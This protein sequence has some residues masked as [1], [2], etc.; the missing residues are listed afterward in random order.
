MLFYTIVPFPR[1]MT[2]VLLLFALHVRGQSTDKNYV[3]SRIYKIATTTASGNIK[4]AGQ[5]ISYID[6]LGREI[7]K[8]D[9][10][11]SPTL[12]GSTPAD[13]VSHF[14]YDSYGRPVRNYA[15]YPAQGNGA[16][17][18]TANLE[19]M[20]Y[21][22]N[23]ANFCAQNDRSYSFT[24]YEPSPMAR[25]KK[26][27]KTGLD[28]AVEYY[29]GINIANEVKKYDVLGNA[30]S[31]GGFY[32]ANQLTFLEIKDENGNRTREY[33]DKREKVIL[34]RVYN[35]TEEL[36]TYYVYDNLLQL[37]FVLQPR[38]QDEANLD[39][40]AFKYQYNDRGLVSSKYVP[41][42]GTTTFQ[43]D[44]KDRIIGTSDGRGRNTYYKY[45]DL[46]RVIEVGDGILNQVENALTK[47]HYDS[48][49]PPFG[50]V[51]GFSSIGDGYPTGYRSNV[52][53]RVTV[54]A[55]RVMN[56]DGSYGQWLYTTFYYD[57]R[58]NL[59][60][61]IR[62]LFDLSGTSKERT[63][64]LVRFD[65]RIEKERILQE[66]GQGNHMIE[67]SFTY[68]HA[69]RLLNTRYVVKK[70]DVTQATIVGSTN[71]YDGIGQLKRKFLHSVD[72]GSTYKE[73]LDYCFTPSSWLSKI[74]GKT[75]VAD[76]FGVELKYGNAT[77]TTP[78]FNGNVAEMLWRQ[79]AGSWVG[80]KFT[81]DGANRMTNSE[82]IN[83]NT[84]RE[85]V[86]SYDKNGN[87]NALQRYFN[88]ATWDNLTYSYEG[89]RLLKVTD[90]GSADGFNNG[91]S[92]TSNDYAYDG[93]GN[94]TQDL[95]RGINAGNLKY[96]HLNLPTDIVV[97]GKTL[98]YYYD[99]LGSKLRMSNS[100]GAV[101][102][103][104]AG[105]FEYN[106]AGYLSRIAIEEGQINVTNNGNTYAF[107]YYL[108]DHLG[109]TRMVMNESGAIVQET[110]YFAFG[111]LIPRTVGTNKYLYNGKEKQPETNYFDFGA[112]Q[113]DSSI[114]RWLTVDPSAED[115]SQM[116]KSVF[117]YGWNNPAK[118]ADPDGKLPTAV[119]GFFVGAAVE[120]GT[121][122][123][124]NIYKDGKVSAGAFTK[125]I[126][127]S[128]ILLAGVEGAVTQGASAG[129]KLLVK[130]AVMVAD[131]TVK[132]EIDK[133]GE[134]NF[135]AEK[136]VGNII[137]NTAIDAAADAITG[138]I[139]KSSANHL[140]KKGMGESGNKTAKAVKDRLREK[141]ERITREKNIFVKQTS[142][143]VKNKFGDT[144]EKTSEIILGP[145]KDKF[146]DKT[147]RHER[148]HF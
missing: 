141:G 125:N 2:I 94:A 119:V 116:D 42:G 15:H 70:N 69:D 147:D 79:T 75:S 136:N 122:V 123:A 49:S 144:V 89:N 37:K 131:N 25:I 67:K 82:G 97:S 114:G 44:T 28:R 108:K 50:G 58:Y 54:N 145:E 121:Q 143:K 55:S 4:D 86:S 142:K 99:G 51:E 22:N 32:G 124:T 127:M 63:T 104:Y 40:Y 20:N 38:Y 26:Q 85:A 14:E 128:S 92:G 11:E 129:R 47:T 133:D 18:G 5:Q 16:Y 27:Y 8:V 74:T 78:Q 68:D 66:T 93:N 12:S 29:Y 7:Q 56:P 1:V 39:R 96:N 48:Y 112:R 31:D 61:T 77:N 137:K 118:N 84:Y 35:G 107:E 80:Y 148:F 117:A 103:K 130:T 81:Y 98:Q 33:Q 59:I 3:I 109:N 134:V 105:M 43:Y 53:G 9:A 106:T 146:K 62:N 88:G 57:D 17:Q 41:G 13:L 91:S 138:N 87:I 102:T 120:Y 6:G 113:Y 21:Y 132:F 76:N 60:Q 139:I 72:E 23:A 36:N 34:K 101:N 19:S 65:G 46:N 126:A 24:E 83:G 90:A 115:S 64:K 30:V 140:A 110:E 95:N 100:N 45:D 73:Q 10:H 111:L 71:R 135:A 52:K